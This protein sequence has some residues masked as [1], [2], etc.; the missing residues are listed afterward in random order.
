MYYNDDFNNFEKYNLPK[1]SLILTD[2]PYCID[3]DAYASNPRW[4]KNGNV[5]DGRSEKANTSFFKND[6]EFNIDNFLNF[7]KKT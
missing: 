3:K 6:K 1:A 2:I 5:K 7:C 4:W